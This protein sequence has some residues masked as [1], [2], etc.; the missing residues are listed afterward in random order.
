MNSADNMGH[1]RQISLY[2]PAKFC[3]IRIRY[4][5]SEIARDVRISWRCTEGTFPIRVTLIGVMQNDP[6]RKHLRLYILRTVKELNRH[7]PVACKC[8]NKFQKGVFSVH[9]TSNYSLINY[10]ITPSIRQITLIKLIF[11]TRK[12]NLGFLRIFPSWIQVSY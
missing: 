1:T 4:V 3:C 11:V 12:L 8:N 9:E 6:T 5:V 10:S 2:S 7:L